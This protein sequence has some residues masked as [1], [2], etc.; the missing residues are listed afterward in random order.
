LRRFTELEGSVS[1]RTGSGRG[2]LWEAPALPG[3]ARWPASV[4]SVRIPLGD[5]LGTGKHEVTLRALGGAGA[6]S[7]W[8]RGLIVGR[9]EDPAEETSP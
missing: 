5:D 7:I 4:G 9:V 2:L 1:D 8:V 6:E 3:D